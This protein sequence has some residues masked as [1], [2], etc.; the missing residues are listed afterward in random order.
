ML[1]GRLSIFRLMVRRWVCANR[2]FYRVSITLDT[3]GVPPVI[4]GF[5]LGKNSSLVHPVEICKLLTQFK[6]VSMRGRHLLFP[7]LTGLTAAGPVSKPHRST[8]ALALTV[9]LALSL[10]VG[11]CGSSVPDDAEIMA[12]PRFTPSSA[13][14]SLL[15]RSIHFHDPEGHWDQRTVHLTWIDTNP[16]GEKR[17]AFDMMMPPG[18]TS[19]AIKG[20]YNGERNEVMN[21]GDTIRRLGDTLKDGH[22][23]QPDYPTRDC[24]PLRSALCA[25]RKT[26]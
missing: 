5:A 26:R 18:G 13:A 4:D 21:K 14:D 1:S 23:I 2:F 22:I 15:A 11:A 19:F 24:V 12:E 7:K 25:R 9:G 3:S 8:I 20:N 16:E 17:E 6:E 10:G